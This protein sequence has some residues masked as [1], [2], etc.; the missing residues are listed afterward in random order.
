MTVETNNGVLVEV[1]KDG[2]LVFSIPEHLRNKTMDHWIEHLNKQSWHAELN[3]V[4][5]EFKVERKER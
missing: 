5:G 3:I 1:Q 4:T 2:W